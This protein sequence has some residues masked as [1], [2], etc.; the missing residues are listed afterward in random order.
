MVHKLQ[1]VF[2]TPP[3]EQVMGGGPQ[4]SAAIVLNWTLPKISTTVLEQG[5][6]V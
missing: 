4:T 3:A 6:H 2:L 5:T 1:S